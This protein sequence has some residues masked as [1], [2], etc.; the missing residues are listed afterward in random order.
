MVVR[1]A[2]ACHRAT[3]GCLKAKAALRFF[4]DKAKADGGRDDIHLSQKDLAFLQRALCDAETSRRRGDVRAVL[5][6]YAGLSEH[7]AESKDSNTAVYFYE[8][9]LEVAQNVGD[10]SA[11]LHTLHSLGAVYKANGDLDSAIAYFEAHRDTAAQHADATAGDGQS[12]DA[13]MAA[14][15]FKAEVRRANSSLVSVYGAAAAAAARAGDQAACL[16]SRQRALEAAQATGDAAAEAATNF[17]VGRTYVS[18]GQPSEG[19]PHLLRYLELSSDASVALASEALGASRASGYAGLAAAY[20]ALGATDKATTCL[21]DFLTVAEE[22][23]DVAAQ[24]HACAS[25]GD[26]HNRRGEFS[27]AVKSFEKSYKLY[28]SLVLSKASIHPD[29]APTPPLPTQGG[30]APSKHSVHADVDRAKVN[31]GMARGNA[32]LGA[33][34]NVIVTDLGALLKWKNKRAYIKAGD[35]AAGAADA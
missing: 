13:Q 19:I 8:K 21:H 26:I 17:H 2:R 10:V 32:T 20:H 18:A 28:R 16:Q 27:R 25:L 22:A 11:E 1:K 14:A 6:A 7:Y 31:L 35:I 15:P 12:V 9:C 29:D 33:Y 34:V 30:A 24:A 23:G 3:C 5:D 4:A